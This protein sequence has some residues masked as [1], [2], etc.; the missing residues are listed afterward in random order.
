MI[1]DNEQTGAG[2]EVVLPLWKAVAAQL[3]EEGITYGCKVSNESLSKMLRE[4]IDSMGFKTG[5]WMIT[6]ELE[7][8]GLHWTTR[9]QN[10]TGF[11]VEPAA[12][13]A[14]VMLSFQSQAKRLVSR[15]VGL[16]GTT[17]KSLLTAEEKLRH[18]KVLEKA[19][20]RYCLISLSGKNQLRKAVEANTNA[21]EAPQI[22]DAK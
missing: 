11:I 14:D 4:P 13:N 5:C 20:M 2:N 12:R 9:G 21:P 10:D 19:A 8:H 16:G 22:E 7:K 1:T 3:L 6:Q 18:E 15:A 17:D